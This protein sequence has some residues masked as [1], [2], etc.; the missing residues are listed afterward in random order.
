MTPTDIQKPRII[1][2]SISESTDMAVFGLSD[3]H[4][5]EAMAEIAMHLLA[6]GANLTYGGDLRRHGFTEL[7]FELV[8][9]YQCQTNKNNEP[10]VINY[11]AWP[12]HICMTTQKLVAIETEFRG[13]VQLALIGRDGRRLAMEDRLVLL[14][15]EADEDEW[16]LGLTAMRQ[17]MRKE[18]DA[19]ILLGGRVD[20]YKGCM[21]GIAE[22]AL[23]SLQSGQPVFLLGGFGGCTRDIAEILGLVKRRSDSR[24]VWPGCQ[25]FKQY[26][27]ENL[28]NGLSIEENQMLACTPYVDQAVTLVLK[29]LHRLR[30]NINN[31]NKY[32]ERDRNA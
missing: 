16:S 2:I 29:G 8:L 19:R 10:K 17:I 18:T 6:S 24:S 25:Q 14:V 13:S 22:E 30:N 21:P 15:R 5:R 4:L 12:V 9:R 32:Q 7:L 3:E 27:P 1:A 20:G 26:V 23:L 31:D 11:L 28:H